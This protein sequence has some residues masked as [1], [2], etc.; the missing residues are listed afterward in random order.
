M[1]KIKISPVMAMVM[2]IGA[3]TIDNHLLY[4]SIVMFHAGRDSWLS[5]IAA[6][7][8]AVLIGYVVGTLA[9]RHP[10]KT[11]VEYTRDILGKW[12]G[13]FTSILIV[14]FFLFNNSLS[15]IGF[16]EFFT[17]SITPRTPNTFYIISITILAVYAL[18]KGLEVTARTALIILPFTLVIGLLASLLTIKNKDFSNLLPIMEFGP[19]PMFLGMYVLLGLY[20]K[21]FVLTMIFPFTNGIKNFP[22]YTILTLLL[23]TVINI[24]P[25]T[26]PIAIFGIDTALKFYFPT[27]QELRDIKLAQLPRL[28]ML[29]VILWGLG[30]FIKVSLFHFATVLGLSQLL[31]IENY[32]VLLVPVGSLLVFVAMTTSASIMEL[33]NHLKYTQPSIT[34]FFAIIIPVIL[35]IV[36]WIRNKSNYKEKGQMT[37]E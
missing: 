2:V 22:K 31:K 1:G 25:I 34:F 24:G 3:I 14:V 12:L 33:T 36:D 35:L 11:V 16:S 27:Y 19:E 10:G 20:G 7:V 15:L 4:F 30:S 28:D 21:V 17:S 5:L 13:T 37:N 6:I 32:K 9:R 8:P 26:G 18:R 23:L 29:G